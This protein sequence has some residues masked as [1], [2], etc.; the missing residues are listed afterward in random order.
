M[1]AAVKALAEAYPGRRLAVVTHGGVLDMLWRT[2][3]GLALDGLRTCDIPNT[4]LN[5]L[6]WHQGTLDIVRWADASHLE[7]LPAQA[8]TAAGER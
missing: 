2:A 4:V 5:H 1:I 8:G 6:R 3:H 7:G